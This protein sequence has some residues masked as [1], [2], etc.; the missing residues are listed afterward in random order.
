MEFKTDIEIAQST[1]MLP[2][3]EVAAK[4]GVGQ[5]TLE[6]YGHYKAKLDIHALK[7]LPRKAKLVLV[8]A[9]SPTPAGEGKTT[10][11]VGLADA[12]NR[13][14]KKTVVCLREPSLG[15]VFGVKGGAAGGGYAQ[16]V[17]MED[18]NLHFTGD[19]HA[20]GAANNLMA[21]LLDNH[22]QQGNVLDIDVRRI[23]WKRAVDMNDR[24]LRHIICGLGGKA[25]GVP[26]EDGFEI[27][28]AS[29]IMAVLCLAQNL[30]DMKERLAKMVV[31]YT[32]DEKPVTAHDLHAEGAMAALLKDA[33]KP[34]LVQTLEHT[35]ALIHGGPFANIAHGCNS[36]QATQ[37]AMKLSEYTVTEAGFAADLG[38]E[39]FLDIKCRAGGFHPDAVVVVA[40][41][42]ALKYHGGVA[43]ADLNNENLE[44]LEKGLP[45]LLQ[46]VENVTKVYGLPCVVAINAFPTDTA[47]ELKMVEDKCR[48]LGVNVALSEVW[49]K[50]GEGG[51][52][53]AQEVMHL[54][55]QPNNFQFVYDAEAGI[56]EKLNAIATKVYRADGVVLAPAAKKQ[57]QQLTELGFDKLPIC[58]AKTQFSFSDDAGKLGAPRG[59]KITVRDLKVNAGAGFLVAKTGDIMTMPGLPKVPSADRIDVDAQGRISGLF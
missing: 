47:A 31:A 56:E 34:N 49:A 48:E 43:K 51:E 6:P 20:I 30:E 5:E 55:E 29:E 39:K 28:V 27:T 4:L 11:S 22:I 46:H 16:V 10:T 8:T 21:A 2:I 36:I 50:G 13:L 17:P 19:F 37:T 58:M 45:N 23:V 59:F 12:L 57:M 54:C 33:I 18:I 25:S 32:R 14:G 52:A 53:L 40:T 42:R 44:A 26:R 35:P 1:A 9:I 7:D 38:A 3:Q 15:P 41:V 24:Q